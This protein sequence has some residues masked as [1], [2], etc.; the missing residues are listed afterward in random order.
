M[1]PAP[2]LAPAS[3]ALNT[4]VLYLGQA[5]GSAVGGLF[6]ARDLP[7]LLGFVAICF[8]ALARSWW[9]RQAVPAWPQF[10][11]QGGWKIAPETDKAA[12]ARPRAPRAITWRSSGPASVFRRRTRVA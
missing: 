9:P 11:P 1:L 10:N 5:I 6:F 12:P 4:A 3:V 8:V 7:Q 2:P